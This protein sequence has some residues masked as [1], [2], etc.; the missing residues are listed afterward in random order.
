MSAAKRVRRTSGIFRLQS[1]KNST[2]ENGKSCVAD[3]CLLLFFCCRQGRKP[4]HKKP[5]LPYGR[6]L[7][8]TV[9]RTVNG[10]LS[11][12]S[13]SAH[14][15][16]SLVF[17]ILCRRVQIQDLPLHSWGQIPS[18]HKERSGKESSTST[19]CSGPGRRHLSAS[20]E[21]VV[22]DDIVVGAVL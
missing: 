17:R 1:W 22:K 4:S 20:D 16:G 12:G 5:Q 13:C 9:L 3:K 7:K 2:S 8:E 14:L 10:S 18:L 15:F 19:M 11:A 21:M 6:D